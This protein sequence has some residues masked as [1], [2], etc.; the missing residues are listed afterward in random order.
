MKSTFLTISQPARASYVIK[1]SKFIADIAPVSNAATAKGMLAQL[2]AATPKANHHCYAYRLVENPPAERFSDD[3][4]PVGTAGKPLLEILHHHQLENTLI[5]VTRYFGGIK[6]GA[7][8]L[9]RAYAQAA[10][11]AVAQTTLFQKTLARQLI[12]SL[13]YP[14]LNKLRSFLNQQQL[15][16]LKTTYT[17]QVTIT[18]AVPI[19]QVSTFQARVTESLTGQAHYQLG[20]KCYLT[21]PPQP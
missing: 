2:T 14:Q 20:A 16:I 6:L 8:G 13:D 18:T 9:I 12:I 10:N 7:G 4:E 1:K 11:A 15:P 3:G 5:V 21:S 17:E 19:A